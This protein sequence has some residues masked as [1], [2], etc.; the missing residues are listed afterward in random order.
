MEINN[1]LKRVRTKLKLFEQEGVY[2]LLLDLIDEIDR[3]GEKGDK[4]MAIQKVRHKYL[5]IIRD[6]E[7]KDSKQLTIQ[8]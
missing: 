7:I 5:M 2:G 1:D 8:I 4:I 6:N 3:E